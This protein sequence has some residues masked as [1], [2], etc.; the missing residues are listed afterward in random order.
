MGATGREGSEHTLGGW[1]TEDCGECPNIGDDD[2]QQWHRENSNP[3]VHHL[4]IKVDVRTGQLEQR[5]NV[6]VEIGHFLVATEGQTSCEQ[7]VGE[8]IDVSNHPRPNN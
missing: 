3:E 5:G 1:D 6:A 4:H 8:G 7:S 2:A